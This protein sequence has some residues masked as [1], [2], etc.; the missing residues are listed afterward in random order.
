MASVKKIDALRSQFLGSCPQRGLH[1]Q[2]LL[3]GVGAGLVS[4]AAS[5]WHLRRNPYKPPISPQCALQDEEEWI[6]PPSFHKRLA[7]SPQTPFDIFLGSVWKRVRS[8]TP[9]VPP[10]DRL[11]V[12]SHLLGFHFNGW[13]DL[14]PSPC[15]KGS[16]D[17]SQYINEQMEWGAID[18]SAKIYVRH[19]NTYFSIV[20]HH[21]KKIYSV[22]PK[23]MPS[24]ECLGGGDAPVDLAS[25]R[26][27]TTL[28]VIPLQQA[29]LYPAARAAFLVMGITTY[30]GRKVARYCVEVSEAC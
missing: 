13:C 4:F 11:M 2:A 19:E 3:I 10:D 26:I 15:P 1:R 27:V 14:L 18:V 20:G 24:D 29:S 23:E 28:D 16:V 25:L 22:S 12:G 6:V 7:A 9:L 17:V 21:T 8:R 30:L 5:Y